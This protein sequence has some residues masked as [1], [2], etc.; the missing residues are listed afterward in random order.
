[1]RRLL[2]TDLEPY[3]GAVSPDTDGGSYLVRIR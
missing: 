1:V 3:I 2:E